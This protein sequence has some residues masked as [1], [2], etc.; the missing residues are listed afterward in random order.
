MLGI[1]I[2][3]DGAKA[4]AQALESNT[5]LTSIRLSST[6]LIELLFVVWS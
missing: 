4:I 3:D 6:P 1:N 5:T 2:G